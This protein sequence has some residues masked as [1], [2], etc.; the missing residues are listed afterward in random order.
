MDS[1]RT[2]YRRAGPQFG[3][4]LHDRLQPVEAG[5]HL[6]LV[7]NIGATWHYS[8]RGGDRPCNLECIGK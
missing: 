4:W 1:D 8:T 2:R 3:C 6:G 5:L 7:P